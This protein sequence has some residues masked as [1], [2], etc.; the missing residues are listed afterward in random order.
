MKT[1]NR[2]LVGKRKSSPRARKTGMFRS[3]YKDGKPRLE[4]S[5]KD[6]SLNGLFR[7]WWPNGQLNSELVYDMGEPRLIRKFSQKNGEL[8]IEIISDG[9]ASWQ[10]FRDRATRNWKDLFAVRNK[11]VSRSAYFAYLKRQKNVLPAK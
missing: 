4:Y 3:W 6:G 2:K 9:C 10:R 11:N 7:D 8:D 5:V 1:A